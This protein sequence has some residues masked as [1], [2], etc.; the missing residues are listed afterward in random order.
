MAKSLTIAKDLAGPREDFHERPT[1]DPE[2]ACPGRSRQT[3]ILRQLERK[4]LWLSAWMVHNANHIRPNRDGLKVGGH[5]AS[6]ASCISILAALYFEI[7]RRRTASRSSRMP[8]RS[9]MSINY[10]F[11]R[12]TVR[13]WKGCA[14][15]AARSRILPV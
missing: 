3:H 1:H 15:S 9:F 8:G 6:C 14:S 5:Q 7:A 4:L 2:D 10:L 12:Q 13:R 11:G